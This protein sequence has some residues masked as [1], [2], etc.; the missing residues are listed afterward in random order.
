M[1]ETSS[2]D[3]IAFALGLVSG[4]AVSVGTELFRFYFFRP[5]LKFGEVSIE[6]SE[7]FSCASLRVCNRGRMLA[8]D[9][10]GA[11]TIHNLEPSNL[12]KREDARFVRDLGMDADKFSI[13]GTETTF[14][15]QETYREVQC[16]SLSWADITDRRTSSIFPGASS[17]L[18]I[19][20][21]VRTDQGAQLHVPSATGWQHL[22]AVMAPG[23]YEIE[24][25]VGSKTHRVVSQRFTI[26]CTADSLGLLKRWH[27]S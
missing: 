27:G 23:R 20:R 5:R 26:D 13:H 21:L 14:L 11:I 10:R 18:D 16:E 6:R 12:L 8:E 15:S 7:K 4:A 1:S 9:V 19:C 22:L 2:Y 25:T 17:L 3:L 24:I